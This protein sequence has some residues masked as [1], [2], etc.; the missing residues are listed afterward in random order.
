MV[1]EDKKDFNKML[2]NNKDMPKIKIL[3]DE[4]SIKRYGG[5]KMFL[6]P[7]LYYDEV[8]KRIPKGKLITLKDIR[9]YFAKKYETDFTCPMTAGIFVNIVA[10]A[11]YQRKEDKTPFW[12]TLKTNG[13]LNPK[14]PE[15][16]ELQKSKLE[17]EGHTIITKGRKHIKYYVED[18]EESLFN[19]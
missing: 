9:E 19:L 3:T 4:K 18:Y 13:E 10:W 1:N 7:P 16:I 6:A 17:A 8:M 12:R 11:S 15:A 14:Y 2:N 5:E